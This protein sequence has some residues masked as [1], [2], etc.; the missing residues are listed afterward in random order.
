MDPALLGDIEF[1]P[2]GLRIVASSDHEIFGWLDD[3]ALSVRLLALLFPSEISTSSF[4]GHVR[5]RWT[6]RAPERRDMDV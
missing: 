3:S 4:W 5:W 1:L 6:L 2:L